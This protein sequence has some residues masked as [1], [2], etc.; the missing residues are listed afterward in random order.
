MKLKHSVG[1]SQKKM[2]HYF[3]SN[4]LTLREANKEAEKI[5]K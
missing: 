2:S 4:F 3:L 1:K 5:K